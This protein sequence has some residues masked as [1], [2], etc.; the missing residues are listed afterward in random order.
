MKLV[1]MLLGVVLLV[2]A[3]VYFLV[4][5]DQLPSFLPGH[6]EGVTRVHA[7]HGIVSGVAG[8]VLLAAGIWMGRR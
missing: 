5:A 6:E 4:P 8:L 7:K 3:A 2:I 1:L